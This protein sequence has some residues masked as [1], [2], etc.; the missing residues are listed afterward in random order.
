[1]FQN[2]LMQVEPA[3]FDA[4]RQVALILASLLAGGFVVPVVNGLKGLLKANGWA[5]WVITAVV[6]AL[7]GAAVVVAD[8]T[9]TGETLAWENLALIFTTVFAAA[10]KVYRMLKD[11]ETAS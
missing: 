2:I 4:I 6:S 3:T 8:G 7:L 10:E 1:M 9:I 5:S 11:K